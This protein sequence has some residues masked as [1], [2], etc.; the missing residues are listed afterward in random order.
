MFI[1]FPFCILNQDLFTTWQEVC[2][3]YFYPPCN[4]ASPNWKDFRPVVIWFLKQELEW[5]RRWYLPPTQTKTDPRKCRLS[6]RQPENNRQFICNLPRWVDQGKQTAVNT[7]ARG[8]LEKA[9]HKNEN[10]S[11]LF[12][13]PSFSSSVERRPSWNLV[14]CP[15]LPF[16]QLNFPS[17]LWLFRTSEMRSLRR[18]SFPPRRFG[19][20]RDIF[21]TLRTSSGNEIFAR[22]KCIPYASLHEVVPGHEVLGR[23]A[24]RCK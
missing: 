15:N 3:E 22:C 16:Q 11:F 19:N 14:Y 12:L 8:T 9:W 13:S 21:V 4:I 17:S 24:T 10:T 2:P 6:L 5:T 1:D 7:L 20:C 18:L 23:F